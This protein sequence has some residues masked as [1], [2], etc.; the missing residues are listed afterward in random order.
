MR[1]VGIKPL[2]TPTILGRTAHPPTGGMPARRQVRRVLL[3][4]CYAAGAKDPKNSCHVCDPAS[5]PPKVAHLEAV[6]RL[7]SAPNNHILG[8]RRIPV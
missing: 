2:A 1:L 8:T 3:A 5:A 6:E 4:I 7:G